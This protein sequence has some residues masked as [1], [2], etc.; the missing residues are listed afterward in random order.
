MDI[1]YYRLGFYWYYFQNKKNHKFKENIKLKDIIKLYYFDFDLKMLLLRYIYRIE[2]HFRT[3]LIYVVSNYHKDNNTWYTD[4]KVV[5]SNILKDFNNIYYNLKTKN[6]IIR[7]HHQKHKCQHAPA[8]KIFEFLTFGQIFKIYSNL[9]NIELKKDITKIYGVNNIDVFTNFFLSLINIRNIC[10]HN[11]VL[12]D[13]N[14]PKGIRKI[15][16]KKYR[17]RSQNQTNLNASLKLLLFILSK[18]SKNRAFELQ[19][20]VKEIFNEGRKCDVIKK[21]IEEKIK[22]EY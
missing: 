3:Q 8:W 1:G 17:I 7:K 4:S 21:I 18:V 16:D 5:N 14:Q 22:F 13:F 2:V 11:G 9:K 20:N 19:K 10:S 6:K 12:Y 15:P